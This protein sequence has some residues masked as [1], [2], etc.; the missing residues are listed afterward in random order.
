MIERFE[1]SLQSLRGPH[2]DITMEAQEIQVL[3]LIYYY[4]TYMF[5]KFQYIFNEKR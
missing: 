1:A 3:N 4:T 2:V 5:M